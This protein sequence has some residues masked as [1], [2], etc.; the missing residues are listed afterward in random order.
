[1]IALKLKNSGNI[2]T[3]ISII[4]K[5]DRNLSM[6]EIKKRIE[7]HEILL[8]HDIS[9]GTDICDEMNDIDRN[10]LFCKL[11]QALEAKDAEI[12]LYDDAEEITIEM[13]YNMIESWNQICMDTKCDIERELGI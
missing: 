12:E 3:Y 7:K 9:A 6:G 11:L 2:M 8:L 5:F 1:M 10:E 4:R 13:L